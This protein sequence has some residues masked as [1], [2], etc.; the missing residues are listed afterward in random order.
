M[1][2][3]IHQ[4]PG[5][6]TDLTIIIERA[7][8]ES[9]LLHIAHRDQMLRQPGLTRHRESTAEER[10]ANRA[11]KIAFEEHLNGLGLLDADGRPRRRIVAI[12]NRNL[13]NNHGVVAWQADQAPPLF[14]VH[15]DPLNYPAYSC[16]V[17]RRDGDLEIRDLR[18]P[19]A[20]RRVQD[21]E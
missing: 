18:F 15:G 1:E 12:G 19:E 11:C 6:R 9:S 7:E 3:R 21:A 10:E 4:A 16:F 13:G 14:H 17:A 2:V 5:Y 20:G 8:I